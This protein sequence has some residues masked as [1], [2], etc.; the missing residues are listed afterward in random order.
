[1][2]EDLA[3]MRSQKLEEINNLDE[4]LGDDAWVCRY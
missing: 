3:N 2:G 1:M 4:Y